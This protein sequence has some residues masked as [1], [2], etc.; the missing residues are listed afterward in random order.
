MK[1]ANWSSDSFYF[2]KV[3]QCSGDPVYWA[4]IMSNLQFDAIPEESSAAWMVDE[5]KKVGPTLHIDGSGRWG[6]GCTLKEE[7]FKK[8]KDDVVIHIH[9]HAFDDEITLRI[10]INHELVHEEVKRHSDKGYFMEYMGR[11]EDENSFF[12]DFWYANKKELEESQLRF[13]REKRQRL[14]AA[15]LK[16]FSQPASV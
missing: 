1:M 5:I 4:S 6:R 11:D 13:T 14:K 15:K 3:N 16:E 9:S 8:L 2:G 12:F 10:T 7:C